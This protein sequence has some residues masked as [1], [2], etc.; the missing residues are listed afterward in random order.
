MDY[1]VGA[2]FDRI[3]TELINSMIRNMD[4]H[5]AEELK[6]GYN[7]EMWQTLQLKQLEKY[8]RVSAKKYKGQF[9]DINN[10]IE[11]L[12]RQANRKGYMSEEA[13]ILKAIKK[14]F[15]AN[16]SDEALNGAFFRVN[17]RKPDALIQ[18]TV[19]LYS[20]LKCM[21]TPEQAL[22]SRQ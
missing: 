7:W 20:M 19:K 12:I 4:R 14:G 17:E 15:F 8:K 18:A 2:A 16:K 22:M 13:K 10:K 1:D 5:R 9:K 6:E 3:E 21:P 11:L